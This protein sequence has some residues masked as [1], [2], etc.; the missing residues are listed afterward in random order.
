ME[1]EHLK[2]FKKEE[3]QEVSKHDQRKKG[4]QLIVYQI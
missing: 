3:A 2:A 4:A 1:I